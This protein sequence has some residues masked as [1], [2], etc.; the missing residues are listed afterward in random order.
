[1]MQK[2]GFNDVWISRIMRCVKTVSYSRLING[3]LGAQLLPSR[4]LCQGDLIS[5]YL[6]LICV[7]GLSFLLNEAKTSSKIKGVKVARGSPPINHIFFTDESI[8]FCR[9]KTSE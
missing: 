1:M 6:Y 7:E 4:G 3:Q 5:P 8:L 2:L 9:A